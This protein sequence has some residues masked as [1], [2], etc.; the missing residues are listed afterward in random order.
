MSQYE[1]E[2]R[3]LALSALSDPT[4]DGFEYLEFHLSPLEAR[5]IQLNPFAF[6][7]GADEATQDRIWNAM[8]CRVHKREQLLAAE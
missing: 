4:T 8:E 7:M 5:Q 2:R 1:F 6:Y 3:L